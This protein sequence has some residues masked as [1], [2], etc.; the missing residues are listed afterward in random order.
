M[1]KKLL[2]LTLVFAGIFTLAA[3]DNTPEGPTDLEKIAE[4]LVE[5]DLPSETATDLTFPSSGLHDVTI[6]WESSNTDV[7][8]NDGTVTIPLFTEGNKTVTITAYVTIGDNT[9]TKEFTVAV[10]AAATKTD[11]EKVAEAKN[12]LLLADT[13]VIS[14]MTLV[15]TALEATIT[16]SSSNTDYITDAGVVTRPAE[17]AGNATV[18]LTATITVGSESDTKEFEI[19]VPAE[20]GATVYT[21]IQALYDASIIG[22]YIEFTGVVVATFSGGYFVSDG[23][24]SL[25]VYYKGIEPSVGDEVHIKGFYAVY[26]TLYQLSNLTVEEVISTGNA[27]PLTPEVKTVAEI[28]ALD[29]SVK[30]IHGMPYT[31]SGTI[32]EIE[33][34]GYTNLWL[35]DGE[36][37]I[38]IYHYSNSDSLDALKGFLGVDV[39]FTGTYYTFYK[40]QK[41]YFA[42]DGLTADIEANLTP[43]EAFDGDIAVLEGNYPMVSLSDVT[44]PTVG[45]NG[46]VFSGWTSSNAAI[47]TDAGVFQAI[48]AAT[49]TV[50]FTGTATAGDLTET[51]TIE[52]VVPVLSTIAEVLAME[53]DDFF[54]VSGTVYAQYSGGFYLEQG[55]VYI[56]VYSYDVSSTVV[57]GDT[58]TLL[59]KL[60]SYNGLTQ[61]YP[62]SAATVDSQGNTANV[63]Q[64][65][66]T[67]GALLTDMYLRGTKVTVIGSVSIEGDNSNAFIT[68]IAGNK[69]EVYY[70]SDA[71]V[72]KTFDGQIVSIELIMY[73]GSR[74]LFY[75]VA[76]DIT[77]ATYDDQYK[78]DAAVAAIDLGGLTSVA[79]D[80]TLPAD[81]TAAG[82]TFAWATSDAAVVT[83]MGVVTLVG[84]STPSA[85]LTVTATVGSATATRDFVVTLV[86]ANDTTP[87]TVTEAL[88]LADEVEVLVEG[89]IIGEYYSE[90]IIQDP[91]TGAQLYIDE[92]VAGE[93]GDLLVVRGELDTYDANGNM[94]REIE[95]STFYEVKTSTESVFV[96]AAT[97]PAVIAETF[98]GVYTATLTF[99]EVMDDTHGEYAWFTGSTGKKIK[100]HPSYLPDYFND[101]YAAND[102]IELTFTVMDVHWDHTR[103]VNPTWPTLNEADSMVAAKAV[104][105]VSA[106]VSEDLTLPTEMYGVTISWASD[107]AAITDMGVVTRPA[108]DAGDATVTLTATFTRGSLTDTKVFTVTVPELTPPAVPLFISE[109]IEGSSNNKAIEIYNPNNFDVVM[110]G[111]KVALY[112]N[113]AS[114]YGN[115]IDL[116]SYTILAND[117]FV[118]TNASANANIAAQEDVSSNITYFNGDDAVALLLDEAIVDLIGVVGEDPASGYWEAGTAGQT[119]EFTLV[120]N[121]DITTGNTTFTGSEWTEY[122]QDTD[123][124]LG[125]HTTN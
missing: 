12:A 45:G 23:T 61:V 120:R 72:V 48:G 31:V 38:Q 115:N 82:A 13:I 91:V 76:G 111:Y 46:T 80:L 101:V 109:Y 85:T 21:S 70:K 25:G 35:V 68:D 113:G 44:L 122:A 81:N 4:A 7:I 59:G 58:I 116:G 55:G 95:A 118:I 93:I 9:L 49:E 34:G 18:T 20:E 33:D 62:E 26:N 57:E 108:I 88:L 124:Y 41:V 16:W 50:T 29:A 54:Q 53:K 78:A 42:F 99:E 71:D 96:Q 67:V 28:I 123:T 66:G 121:A 84:G 117:V 6:T 94:R 2:T 24:L 5:I 3:C 112:S 39:T 36:N 75:G 100:L 102:T 32:Q 104:L 43:Q 51:V 103:I 19:T 114:E 30:G 27:N 92:N 74:V 17:D 37:K 83:D 69:V 8:A 22:D 60:G 63:A 10:N 56:F 1:L 90:R 65:T 40:S 119:K 14:D 107:N 89:I 79:S 86:D 106:T 64:E 105:E 15:A 125:S 11:A 87:M 97:D 52:V 73:T 47:Y 77:V 98:F 110:T